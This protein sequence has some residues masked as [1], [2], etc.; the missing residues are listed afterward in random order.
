MDDGS[1]MGIGIDSPRSAITYEEALDSVRFGKYHY[2]LT[3][4]AGTCQLI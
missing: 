2:A 3:L 1:D 4:V